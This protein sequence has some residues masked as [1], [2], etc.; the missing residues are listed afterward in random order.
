MIGSGTWRAAPDQVF[1]LM[2]MKVL[3]TK[4]E[5]RQTLGFSLGSEIIFL[6]LLYVLNLSQI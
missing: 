3:E 5:I 2:N 4:K 6:I 1:A